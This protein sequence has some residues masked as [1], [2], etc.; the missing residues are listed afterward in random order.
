MD[1]GYLGGK[2][3][4]VWR[5]S[6]GAAKVAAVFCLLSWMADPGVLFLPFFKLYINVKRFMEELKKEEDPIGREVQEGGDICT[7]GWFILMYGRNQHN[8][9]K[10]WSFNSK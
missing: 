1:S 8:I 10:Q 6:R 4:A 5:R 3:D 2:E 7:C 9:V